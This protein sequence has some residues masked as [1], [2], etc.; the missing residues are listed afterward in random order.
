LTG[1]ATAYKS[2]ETFGS[3]TTLEPMNGVFNWLH[4]APPSVLFWTPSWLSESDGP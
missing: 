1:G 3:G 2:P 4:V